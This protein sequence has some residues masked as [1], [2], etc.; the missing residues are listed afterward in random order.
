MSEKKSNA[1]LYWPSGDIQLTQLPSSRGKT[2]RDAVRPVLENA[3]G[4]NRFAREELPLAVLTGQTTGGNYLVFWV[5]VTTG[6]P[7]L[8]RYG[9]GENPVGECL[10][11]PTVIQG[12]AL[13]VKPGP[14]FDTFSEDDGGEVNDTLLPLDRMDKEVLWAKQRKS[15]SLRKT[16]AKPRCCWPFR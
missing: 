13:V 10:D 14:E 1:M 4:M 2:L 3:M 5:M 15:Y 8:F 16:D 11:T 12:C 9:L 6:A 7:P